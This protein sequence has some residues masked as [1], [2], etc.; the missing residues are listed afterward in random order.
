MGRGQWS[1][2]FGRIRK[3]NI[4]VANAK[5]V[6]ENNLLAI[7]DVKSFQFSALLKLLTAIR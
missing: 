6:N 4:F 5:I 1:P 3:S 7:P 2:L